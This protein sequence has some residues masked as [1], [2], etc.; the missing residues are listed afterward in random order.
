MAETASQQF[1]HNEIARAR[2]AKEAQS[3]LVEVYYL[4]LYLVCFELYQD[5][6]IIFDVLYIVFEFRLITT[7]TQELV[8][9]R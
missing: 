5:L 4:A 7:K 6:M 8:V 3:Q 1:H 2:A 9:L